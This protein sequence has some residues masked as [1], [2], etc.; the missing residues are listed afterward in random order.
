MHQM[1]TKNPRPVPIFIFDEHFDAFYFW[2]VARHEKFL[3]KPLDLYHID[4][5]DDM[6]KVSDLKNSVYF[7]SKEPT[8]YLEHYRHLTDHCLGIADF[9]RPAVLS[10]IV[11]DVYLAYPEWRKKYRRKHKRTSIC[12]A[13]GEGKVIKHG[14][15]ASP[16]VDKVFPDFTTFRYTKCNVSTLPKNRTVILDIDLDYFACCDT[17]SNSYSYELEISE[18][19]FEHQDDFLADLTLRFSGFNFSF[20]M[21]EK[22]RYFAGIKREGISERSYLPSRQEVSSQITLLMQELMNKNIKPVAIT[23]SRSCHSGFCPAEY[24]GF[25][26][27]L[28]L[29]NIKAAFPLAYQHT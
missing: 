27:E 28:L 20:Y 6:G 17:P 21:K 9:I 15:V 2:H 22:N 7:N 13:F 14:L 5:H 4:A 19:Q 10:G 23:V 8:G 26:E 1:K 16:K 29:K 11:K 25:I 3:T 24:V 12:S 18:Q